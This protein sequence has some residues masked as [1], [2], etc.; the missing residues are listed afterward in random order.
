MDIERQIAHKG[1]ES[2]QFNGLLG[3][4]NHFGKLIVDV[5]TQLVCRKASIHLSRFAY[6]EIVPS[7]CSMQHMILVYPDI[8]VQKNLFYL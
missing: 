5:E 2:R 4:A 6:Q 3:Y 1:V 7:K 8:M